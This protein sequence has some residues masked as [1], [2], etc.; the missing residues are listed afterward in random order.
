MGSLFRIKFPIKKYQAVYKK[1][2]ETESREDIYLINMQLKQLKSF[3]HNEIMPIMDLICK[4][5]N[6]LSDKQLKLDYK[7]KRHC[8]M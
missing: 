6:L 4:F 7:L 5:E 2:S 8:G 3:R 1:L